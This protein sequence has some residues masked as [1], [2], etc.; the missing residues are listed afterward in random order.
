MDLERKACFLPRSLDHPIEAIR[1]K[2][3]AALAHEHKRRFLR[4]PSELAQRSQFIAANGVS[5]RL[6]AL[7]PADMKRCGVPVNLLPSQ[8]ADLR[9]PQS[10]PV[11]HKDHGAVPVTIAIVLRGLNE[12]FDLAL[13][14]VLSAAKLAVWPAP[15]GDCS[16]FGGWRDQLQVRFG[17]GFRLL[18]INDCSYKTHFTS[19]VRGNLAMMV[20]GFYRFSVVI[21][22]ADAGVSSRTASLH[23]GHAL[24]KR[25]RRYL[26]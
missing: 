3:S 14:Q 4:L 10:M 2:W 1:G 22:S 19:S 18:A 26:H 17:H 13:S 23:D 20:S 5:A 12:L 11:S 25:R 15:R 8:V 9:S 24:D 6:S 16:F 21:R 7:Y